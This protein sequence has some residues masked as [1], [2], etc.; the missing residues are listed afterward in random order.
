M[1][2]YHLGACSRAASRRGA[3]AIDA[4]IKRSGEQCVICIRHKVRA[5]CVNVSAYFRDSV[6]S[7]GS[8]LAATDS[9]VQAAAFSM[10][11][12]RPT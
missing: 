1:P 8:I 5:L 6:C 9:V 11:G 10:R 3:R 7:W 2:L 12:I 4:E